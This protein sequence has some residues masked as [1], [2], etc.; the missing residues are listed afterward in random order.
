MCKVSIILP[1]LNVS[2]YIE[3][4]IESVINQT[5]EDLEIICVDAGSSDGTFELINLY[6]KKDRRIKV[7]QSPIKS[8]GFQVNMGI[9]YASGEYIGIVE[10]DDFINSSMYEVLYELARKNELD[11]IKC[12]H[13][14]VKG[15]KNNYYREQ[16]DCLETCD[17]AI[18]EKVIVDD[19]KTNFKGYV[20]TWA[21]IYNINFIKSNNIFHNE[22]PGASYQDNGFWFQ[23]MAKAKRV[24][25]IR[26]NLYYLR[27][28]N[29]GSS[30]F[31]TDK[32][33]TIFDEYDFIRGKIIE[34]YNSNKQE[35]LYYCFYYR[36]QAFLMHTRRVGTLMY[37]QF[38]NRFRKDLSY[39]VY[40]DEIDSKMFTDNQLMYLLAAIKSSYPFN[41]YK[42]EYITYYSGIIMR[43]LRA[44]QIAIVGNAVSE[45]YIVKWIQIA[46]IDCEKYK[47][48]ND[49]KS[50]NDIEDVECVI[51]CKK[52]YED[53]A[54]KLVNNQR[55]TIYE[56]FE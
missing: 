31:A 37:E 50:K 16:M 15:K 46:G 11:C 47:V 42:T 23:I 5:L 36:F 24:M 9:K 56:F 28:D 52:E 35:Y 2:D 22:S 20:Y 38:Y 25:F 53:Y 40:N 33:E 29:P 6:A 26:D 44:G 43:L 51:M 27:R 45:K 7:L 55:K 32:I 17:D 19:W 39:A 14:V 10:T 12:G 48:I 4:C 49:T 18:Y 21:G 54:R 41:Y 34:E 8:Y 13:Y 3:E 1:S 30:M